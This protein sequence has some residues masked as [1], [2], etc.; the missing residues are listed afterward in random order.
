MLGTRSQ[1]A[2]NPKRMRAR[3][4]IATIA[5]S[6]IPCSRGRTPTCFNVDLEIPVPIR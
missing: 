5:Q 2:M 4:A 3:E 6:K 1:I